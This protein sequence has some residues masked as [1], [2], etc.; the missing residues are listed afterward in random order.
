MPRQ[1]KF[2]I[3]ICSKPWSTAWQAKTYSTSFQRLSPSSLKSWNKMWKKLITFSNRK[4]ISTKELRSKPRLFQLDSFLKSPQASPKLP[5]WTP[6]MSR[7]SRLWICWT[8]CRLRTTS[9]KN[10]CWTLNHISMRTP[11][12]KMK[13]MSLSGSAHTQISTKWPKT[14][15]TTAIT[16]RASPEKPSSVST[17]TD[18]FIRRASAKIA[19]LN[20]ITKAKSSWSRSAEKK[21]SDRNSLRERPSR[22]IK[23]R[24]PRQKKILKKDRKFN[25]LNYLKL[26]TL[27]HF[28]VK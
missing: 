4:L 12:T 25:D 3:T 10:W 20:L 11:M 23:E 7:L 5:M 15:A 16:P 26:R 24:L 18:S 9:K 22:Q 2:P 14:C 28:I 19:I 6:K 17:A 1:L 21:G 27:K 8:F 13:I